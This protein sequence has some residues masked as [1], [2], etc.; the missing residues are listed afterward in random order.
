MNKSSLLVALVS[1]SL[2][3]FSACK[4]DNTNNQASQESGI[5]TPDAGP[6]VIADID[7]RVADIGAGMDTLEVKGPITVTRGAD[8]Y[9]ATAYFLNSEPL[10]IHSQFGGVNQWYYLYN[11]RV[12]MLRELL[13]EGKGVVEN[14]FYYSTD[15][16]LLAETRKADA[17]PAL[18]DARA[19]K[20]RPTGDDDYRMDVGAANSSG[21][22]FLYGQ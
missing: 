12:I 5:E 14:K 20:Y 11:R 4:S 15:A 7:R 16:V 18:L 3:A 6:E 19:R 22:G 1:L 13:G 17:E 21:I 8:N 10:I 2:G 9:E